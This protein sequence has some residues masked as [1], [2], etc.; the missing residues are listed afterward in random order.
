MPKQIVLKEFAS[1]LKSVDI[2]VV[3]TEAKPKYG[4]SEVL[5]K[6]ICASF[7]ATDL[8]SLTGAY[9]AFQ[10]KEGTKIPGMECVCVVEEIGEEVKKVLVG[11]RVIPVLMPDLPSKGVGSWQEYLAIDENR[12]VVVPEG[13]S[14][15]TAAQFFVNHFTPYIL[16]KQAEI[17]KDAFIVQNG[18]S[19]I[20]GR[21]II[22]LAK[23]FGFKVINLVHHS[24]Q[25]EE[26]EIFGAEH[27]L[28]TDN[29]TDII[30][31]IIKITQAKLCHVGFDA[32]GGSS[33]VVISNAVNE[34]KKCYLYGLMGGL[35]LHAFSHSI[36]F[37]G[38]S[39]QGFWIV[40]YLKET[41]ME[42]IIGSCQELLQLIKDEVVDSLPGFKME[43][44]Q[45]NEA[46]LLAQSPPRIG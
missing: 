10:P 46:V 43:F 18:A 17:P 38:V 30:K 39:Y 15:E 4:K 7:N 13:V 19:G 22:K 32:I 24:S 26:L 35:E 45:I 36:L 14:D 40:R 6:V 5:L 25:I 33:G 41:P 11:Q 27:V 16:V 1:S 12:V 31:E 20:A 3:E 23:H 42:E 29:T 2:R 9:G 21:Q 28:C 34:G 8:Y 37:R 44:A